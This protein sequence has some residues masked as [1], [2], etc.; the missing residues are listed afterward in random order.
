MDLEVVSILLDRVEAFT[1][2]L[3][4]VCIAH[5]RL[6]SDDLVPMVLVVLRLVVLRFALCRLALK[7]VNCF[8]GEVVCAFERIMTVFGF[9]EWFCGYAGSLSFVLLFSLMRLV[10]HHPLATAIDF[11]C[12]KLLLLLLLFGGESGKLFLGG[13]LQSPLVHRTAH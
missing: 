11:V 6:L 2:V 4:R 13:L 8:F 7:A 3:R 5:G 1:L 10:E 12:L 9:F